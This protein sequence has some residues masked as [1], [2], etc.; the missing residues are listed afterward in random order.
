VNDVLERLQI[1]YAQ[2]CNGE[3]EHSWGVSIETL[4]NPGWLVK[5]NLRATN[6]ENKTLEKITRERS[7]RNWITCWTKDSTFQGAGGPQNL[8]E[9][10]ETFLSWST[11]SI[12]I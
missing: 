2:Q 6:L 11:D 5:I 12:R 7:E 3:W 10:L 8:V 1:W 9:I 4:D